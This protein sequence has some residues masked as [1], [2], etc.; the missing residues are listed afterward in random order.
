MGAMPRVLHLHTLAVVSGSGLNTL[1]TLARLREHGFEGELACGGEGGLADLA[2]DAGIRVHRI[3]HLD[4]SLRPLR[5]ARAL[6]EI[7]ALLRRE[8]F[9]VV[10]TH[11][12][13]AGLLGRLAARAC[14]VPAV[15]HTVH[16]WAFEQAASAVGRAF[17]RAAERGAARVAHR[18]FLV[19]KALANAADRAGVPGSER[20]EVLYS[21]IDL[22]AF[23][24][25]PRDPAL[26][27]ELGA[28]EGTFLVGQVAKLWEG[29]GHQVLIRAFARLRERVPRAR[30]AIVGDGALRS[31]IDGAARNLG[32]ASHV[33]FTGHR[34][35]VARITAQLDAATLFSEYE[36]MGRVVVEALAAGV[37]VVASRRG[38][39]IE[40]VREGETGFL[41]DAADA[42]GAAECLARLAL[43][44]RLRNQMSRNARASVDGR[45]DER[46]MAAR[47]AA[48]Y[49]GALADARGR[50]RARYRAS[51]LRP[52][53]APAPGDSK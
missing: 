22:A 4:R 15:I 7:A 8:R 9:Q 49:R 44:P 26:R 41:V 31:V 34:S 23:H 12:S 32:L 28:G 3:A 35:D 33:T 5:D 50:S 21:G 45:F 25:A 47:I 6:A 10:H 24:G 36:G 39:I 14:G 27:R 53:V 16:G 51:R 11:N 19:S 38:G 52:A 29:K 2:R 1:A 17:Y 43:D 48:V 37:P 20:R 30:L 42:E 46:F 40:L 13:K 18:T